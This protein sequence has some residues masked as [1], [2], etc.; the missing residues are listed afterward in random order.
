MILDGDLLFSEDQAVTAEADATN[1]IDLTNVRDVGVGEPLYIMLLVTETFDDTG[2]DSTLNVDLVTD[3]N[4]AMSSDAVV[5]DLVTLPALTA[6]GT[7]YF[8]P[9]TPEILN[10]YERY[11]TLHYTPANGNLS[12]GKITAGIVKDIQRYTSYAKNYTISS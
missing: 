9:L 4:A 6:A 8:F 1:V 12:A 11:I 3:N 5:Q 7:L 2:D 10:A